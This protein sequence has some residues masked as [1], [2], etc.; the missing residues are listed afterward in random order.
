MLFT[1]IYKYL[2]FY[3][4]YLGRSNTDHCVG[5]EQLIKLNSIMSIHTRDQSKHEW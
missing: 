1:F 2:L 3:H 5:N 4:W